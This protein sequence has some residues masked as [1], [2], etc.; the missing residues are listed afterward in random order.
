MNVDQAALAESTLVTRN[1]AIN[2]DDPT[3]RQF[4]G[5]IVE[6]IGSSASCLI[7]TAANNSIASAVG[8][9]GSE[10]ADA[11]FTV[12]ATP[13]T[14]DLTNAAANTMG[15]LVDFINGLADYKARLVGCL[16]ADDA[17]TIGALV[18]VTSQQAKVAN[19][20]LALALDSSVCDHLSFEVSS[21]DGF[22]YSGTSK[23]T[24]QKESDAGRHAVNSLV[25]IAGTLAYT[26]ADLFR[27][28]EM[29]DFNKTET[30]IYQQ[31]VSVVL[32]ASTSAGTTTFPGAGITGKAGTRLLV[33]ASAATTMACTNY[34]FQATTKLQ[35]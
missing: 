26:G 16:R 18:A 35:V 5:M 28:W 11:N 3:A 27:V 29:D 32:A 10:A 21:Y 1:V 9:A 12:G 30:L 14:I 15:E 13:G 31:L 4:V 19:T 20:G 2:A 33:R 23:K 24:P 25:R 7:T 8:A 17:D 6:Y 34:N 22:M